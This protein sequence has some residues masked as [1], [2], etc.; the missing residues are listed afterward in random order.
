VENWAVG[1][2]GLH[3]KGSGR[4]Y[5]Y[6]LIAL[7]ALTSVVILQRLDQMLLEAM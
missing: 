2:A 7:P 1:V 6:F 5:W 3:F 4:E